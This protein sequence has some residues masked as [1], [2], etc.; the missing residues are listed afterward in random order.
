MIDGFLP[1]TYKETNHGEGSERNGVPEVGQALNEAM[2]LLLLGAT[3]E[4]IGAEVLIC[5]SVLEHVIDGGEEGS[6][7]RHD[8]LLC[9]APRLDA[10][11]LF[12]ELAVLFPDRRPGRMHHC[13]LQP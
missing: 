10:V 12:A 1:L 5:G 3:V 4:V 6:G 13:R 7:D 2:G 9:P 11:E 8:C